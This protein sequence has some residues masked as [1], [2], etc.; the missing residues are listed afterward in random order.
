MLKL[1]HS[2][3]LVDQVLRPRFAPCRRG[4]PRMRAPRHWKRELLLGCEDL[5]REIVDGRAQAL[6]D[7]HTRPP[8][9]SADGFVNDW[10]ST[11]RIVL[12]KRAMVEPR[13]RS[14]LLQNLPGDLLD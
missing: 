8:F 7:R 1:L 2:S 5:Q 4:K 9:E 10:P 13:S 14:C 6:L 12:R 11:L 3:G